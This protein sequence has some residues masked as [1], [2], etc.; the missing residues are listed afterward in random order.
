MTTDNF[1]VEALKTTRPILQAMVESGD[2]LFQSS[3]DGL[4]TIA[5]ETVASEVSAYALAEEDGKNVVSENY[6]TADM[7]VRFRLN[8]F[9]TRFPDFESMNPLNTF[10]AHVCPFEREVRLYLP[11]HAANNVAKYGNLTT[12]VL[13]ENLDPDFG[14]DSDTYV[15]IKNITIRLTEVCE[16]FTLEEKYQMLDAISYV[17]IND[18]TFTQ[19]FDGSTWSLS[20]HGRETVLNATA[21][22]QVVTKSSRVGITGT[23]NIFDAQVLQERAGASYLKRRFQSSMG[24][25][26]EFLVTDLRFEVFFKKRTR[27]L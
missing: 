20:G 22:V 16:T 15:K 25:L 17:E 1:D 27:M 12:L 4:E 3:R 18:T 5:D 2:L 11:G 9:Q 10:I 21:Y 24:N 13:N 19:C 26:M 7:C 14:I 8:D 6:A 23:L